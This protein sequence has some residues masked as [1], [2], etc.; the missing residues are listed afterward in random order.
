MA[1]EFVC[2]HCPNKTMN[3]IDGVCRHI[4]PLIYRYLVDAAAM[5]SN[6]VAL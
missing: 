6:D 2:L 4:D 1:Y 5:S 3:D